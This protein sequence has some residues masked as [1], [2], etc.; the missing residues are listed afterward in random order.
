MDNFHNKDK[1]K[2]KNVNFSSIP[3]DQVIKQI[4]LVLLVKKHV[5][6]ATCRKSNGCRF[7]FPY[8]PSQHTVI[9]RE[10]NQ[11]NYEDYATY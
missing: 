4:D 6:S 5:H 10:Q 1:D 11:N 8:L 7:H 3:C 9:A 2:K